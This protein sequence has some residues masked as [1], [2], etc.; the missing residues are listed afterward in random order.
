MTAIHPIF[1]EK[2]GKKIKDFGFY[3]ELCKDCKTKSP[4]EETK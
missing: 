3:E 4:K 2:C 1:C